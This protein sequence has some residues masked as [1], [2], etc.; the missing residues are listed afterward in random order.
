MQAVIANYRAPGRMSSANVKEKENVK[1]V[2][3]I[4]IQA[5]NLTTGVVY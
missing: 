4:W 3:I 1:P 5:A 2:A